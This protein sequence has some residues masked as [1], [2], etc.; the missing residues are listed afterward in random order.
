MA[1]KG[2]QIPYLEDTK[3]LNL[4]I[5]FLSI[6]LLKQAKFLF[7]PQIWHFRINQVVA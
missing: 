7:N 4:A 3:N 6:S 5:E 2:R 1:Q